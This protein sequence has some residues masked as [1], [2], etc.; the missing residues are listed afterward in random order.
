MHCFLAEILAAVAFTRLLD[1]RAEH[2]VD[3]LAGTG[4]HCH[5]NPP[6]H[7]HRGARGPVR[8]GR[9]NPVVDQLRRVCRAR[10][11]EALPLAAIAMG[12]SL[13]RTDHQITPADGIGALLRYV[14]ND[15]LVSKHSQLFGRSISA[16]LAS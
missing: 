16:N 15:R 10:A 7:A 13:V 5:H 4:G 1:L 12:A 9:G 11:D 6:I 3:Q 2:A 14:A 8:R